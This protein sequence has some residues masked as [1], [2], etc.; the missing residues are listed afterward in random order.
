MKKKFALLL[1]VLS[2]LVCFVMPVCAFTVGFICSGLLC[3][4]GTCR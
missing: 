1:L 3:D 4:A 2:V